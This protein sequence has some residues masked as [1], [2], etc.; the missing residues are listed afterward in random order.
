[1]VHLQQ[2]SKTTALK[3]I[4]VSLTFLSA[5]C[6]KLVISPLVA[7][8]TFADDVYVIYFADTT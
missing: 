6:K 1:M 4:L 2:W 3:E 5:K 7:F 8:L